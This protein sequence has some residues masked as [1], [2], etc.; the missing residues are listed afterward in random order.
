MVPYYEY[1]F[2][3]EDINDDNEESKIQNDSMSQEK[4]MSDAR[5]NM[6]SLPKSPQIP[7]IPKF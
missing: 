3:L 5:K 4:M 1:E 6:P 7:K 2:W